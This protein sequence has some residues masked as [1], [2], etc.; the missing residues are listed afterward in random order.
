M[1]LPTP[2]AGFEPAHTAPEWMF[3]HAIYLR[4]RHFFGGLGHV[5]AVLAVR[6]CGNSPDT[7]SRARS[8]QRPR[9]V[10]G[11]VWMSLA[12]ALVQGR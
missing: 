11:S 7:P 4:K 10:L 6:S 5:W 9:G 8:A 12:A 1:L 3:V 2:P